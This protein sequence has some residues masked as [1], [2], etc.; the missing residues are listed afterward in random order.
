M[1]QIDIIIIGNSG[2]GK[3]CLAKKYVSDNNNENDGDEQTNG[4]PNKINGCDPMEM[5]PNPTIGVDHFKKR[6]KVNDLSIKIDLW[7]TAGQERFGAITKSFFQK[8]DGV[9]LTFDLTDYESFRKI[10]EYWLQQVEEISNKSIKKILIGNKVD[11]NEDRKV[12]ALQG[13]NLASKYNINYFETSALTGES[14]NLS[15]DTLVKQCAFAIEEHKG[16]QTEDNFK[17]IPHKSKQLNCFDKMKEISEK[18]FKMITPSKKNKQISKIDS[19]KQSKPDDAVVQQ[20]LQELNNN[21]GVQQQMQEINHEKE[22][23][24]SVLNETNETQQ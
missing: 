18:F 5:K 13:A 9:I 4:N 20:Q 7:D 15:F 6:I 22:Q 10:E 24:K 21:M 12:S 16:N 1:V 19:T 17:V 2:A 3:T 14:V 8:A 23:S 11:R